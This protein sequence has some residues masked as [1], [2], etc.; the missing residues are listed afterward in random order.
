MPRYRTPKG[1]G[2]TAFVGPGADAAK[3]RPK[4]TAPG[5]THVALSPG[6][7]RGPRVPSQAG[8]GGTTSRK[9]GALAV[10]GSRTVKG[11]VRPP[12][13]VDGAVQVARHERH[14]PCCHAIGRR[15][16]AR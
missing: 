6:H 10:A 9:N 2:A 1:G 13:M 8:A 15:R 4:G 5:P 16:G 11:A 12:L 7:P 14:A 3:P